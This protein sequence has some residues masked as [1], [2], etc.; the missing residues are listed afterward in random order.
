MGIN[1]IIQLIAATLGSLGFSV[2][3]NIKGKKLIGVTLGGFIGWL[4]YVIYSM[5]MLND[6]LCYFLAAVTI[7]IYAEIMARVM[8]CPVTVIIAP[9]LIPLVPGASLYYT[10]AH[11][12]SDS[13]EFTHRAFTTLAIAA[14]LAGGIIFSAI[15]TTLITKIKL[16]INQHRHHIK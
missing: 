8:K 4:A 15:I 1:E 5:L 7:S 3:F 16:F 2:L 6:T 12:L 9:S 11:I 13:G 14:A 10:M